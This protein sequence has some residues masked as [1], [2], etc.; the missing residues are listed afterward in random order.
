ML[1]G[2]IWIQKWIKQLKKLRLLIFCFF[3]FSVSLD[4]QKSRWQSFWL[5]IWLNIIRRWGFHWSPQKTSFFSKCAALINPISIW[6]SQTLTCWMW[7]KLGRSKNLSTNSRKPML[8]D[9]LRRHKTYL[10]ITIEP[11]FNQRDWPISQIWKIANHSKSYCQE[12]IESMKTPQLK[13]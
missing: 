10:R 7:G 13:R 12:I 11:W 4:N 9:S 1:F 3:L 5:A 2:N 6:K 8:K